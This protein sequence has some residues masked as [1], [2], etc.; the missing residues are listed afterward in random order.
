LEELEEECFLQVI[1]K[2]KNAILNFKKFGNDC[3]QIIISNTGIFNYTKLCVKYE[4]FTFRT[5]VPIF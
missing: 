2:A 4:V 1:K 5:V 3:L